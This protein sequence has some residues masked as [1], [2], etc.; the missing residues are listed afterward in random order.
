MENY[1]I[2][3]SWL[4]KNYGRKAWKAFKKNLLIQNQG[5][6]NIED[7][8][9]DLYDQI[10][11][12]DPIDIDLFFDFNNCRYDVK[13]KLHKPGKASGW[14]Q[15]SKDWANHTESLYSGKETFSYLEFDKHYIEEECENCFHM[16]LF[17]CFVEFD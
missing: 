7:Y 4:K 11:H 6:V 16:F 17:K 13:N 15:V 9:D 3:Q 2:F 10:E 8:Y 12:V 1:I 14:H 5:W